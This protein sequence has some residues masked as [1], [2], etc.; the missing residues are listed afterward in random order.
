MLEVSRASTF[1]LMTC[2]DPLQTTHRIMAACLLRA[3][4]RRYL[5][6]VSH[7]IIWDLF[8]TQGNRNRH[9]P[10]EDFE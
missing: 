1:N 8:G 7:I 3:E 9:L 5:L 6:L 4:T 10:A 2:A